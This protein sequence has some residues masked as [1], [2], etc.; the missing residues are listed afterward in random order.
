MRLATC[1]YHGRERIGLERGEHLD[2]LPIDS[3]SLR[4]R[5]MTDPSF[6]S[7]EEPVETVPKG[8][9]EFLCPIPDAG[10]I[11][12]V[13]LNYRGHNAEAG[14]NDPTHPSL[15]VRFADSQVGH[16]QAIIAPA[17]SAEF[18]FEGE[19]A[20]II[21]KPAWR[22]D[23]ADALDH[24]AGYSCFAENS[25]RD[26]QAHARQATAG[27]N[28]LSSGAFGPWLT[29]ADSVG[30]PALLTLV[31]RLNGEVVQSD[32]TSNMIFSVPALIAYISSFTRLEPGDV[33]A[34][35]TPQGVGFTRTPPLWL[36]PGD[37]LAIE[38]ERVGE[39][40]NP[41]T[42]EPDSAVHAYNPR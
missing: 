34:T 8:D 2:L 30:D 24:V 15:F 27:K 5:L 40:V 7:L 11:I 29:T 35:G 1:R 39:L 36:R 32:A 26:F 18:D 10:K 17:N 33:I 3:P 13:G 12:C 9:V 38:I 20:V 25:V 21:G 22:V 16:R 28:F 37:N 6:R 42:A 31:T 4:V 41:V 19:L 23:Q 14:A